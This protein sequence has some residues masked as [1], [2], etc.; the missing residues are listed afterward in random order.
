MF[1]HQEF[2]SFGVL[3]SAVDGKQGARGKQNGTPVTVKFKW[4]NRFLC[5]CRK[6]RF[7]QF[8]RP[9]GKSRAALLQLFD[10]H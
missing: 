1:F 9:L 4:Q 3:H 2:V 7:P 8:K 6:F 10:C 5:Q